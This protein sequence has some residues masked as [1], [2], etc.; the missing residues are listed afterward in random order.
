MKLADFKR[1]LARPEPPEGLDPAMLA[2]WWAHKGAW[3]RAHDVVME[4]QGTE[5]AWVH[6]YLHRVEGDLTNAQYWYRQAH[7]PVETGSLH[8]E[9]DAIAAALLESDQPE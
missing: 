8:A 7:K 4:D 5:A 6:A 3:D 2:L 1:S 9:W